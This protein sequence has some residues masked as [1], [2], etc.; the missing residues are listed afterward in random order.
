MISP[1]S[2]R[3]AS[4]NTRECWKKKQHVGMNHLPSPSSSSYPQRLPECQAWAMAMHNNNNSQPGAQSSSP[5]L[6]AT[7]HSPNY[8]TSPHFL[9]LLQGLRLCFSPLISF[10]STLPSSTSSS[11]PPSPPLRFLLSPRTWTPPSF[12]CRG[13]LSH[14]GP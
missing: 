7:T 13:Q 4:C 1:C 8:L 2:F 5:S 6:A 11:S 3:L 10:S 12:L 14:F 9:L